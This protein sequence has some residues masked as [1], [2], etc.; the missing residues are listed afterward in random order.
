MLRGLLPR[1]PAHPVDVSACGQPGLLRL[2]RRCLPAVH[3][4]DGAQRMGRRAA[5]GADFGGV[6]GADPRKEGQ[7]CTGGPE[8]SAEGSEGAQA[9]RDARRA[10]PQFRDPGRAQVHGRRARLARPVEA[11]AAAAAGH[12]LLYFPVH[13]LP[14]GRVQRQDG[15]AAQSGQVLPV[16]LLFPAAAAGPDR[17]LR[18]PLGPA[19]RAPRF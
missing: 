17:P 3:P 14:A 7:P 10:R 12:L 11:R 8:E 4:A 18:R 9:G 19:D 13:R 6:R 16:C 2:P 5:D 15:A 1:P